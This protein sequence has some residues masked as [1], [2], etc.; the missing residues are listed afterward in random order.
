MDLGYPDGTTSIPGH[1]EP[2]PNVDI[3]QQIAD[4][5]KS[6]GVIVRPSERDDNGN[7][8]WP[9]TRAQVPNNPQHILQFPKDL[10]DEIR[11]GMEIPDDVISA[12]GSGAW[13][14]KRVTLA[15]FYASL[16]HWVVQIIRDLKSQIFDH[17]CLLNWGYVPEYEIA[18]KPLAE[19]AMEQQANAGPGAGGSPYPTRDGDGDGMIG[20][21]YYRS[22]QGPARMSLD[23]VAAVGEGVL[24]A[25]ELVEA[26][27]RVMRMG[28]S[29]YKGDRGGQ[30]W[31]HSETGEVRYQRNKPQD[32]GNA[33]RPYKGNEG[34][35]GLVSPNV[36]TGMS[37]EESINR[38]SQPR[39]Q[40]MK[41]AFYEVGSDLGIRQTQ[42][43]VAGA[44]RDGSE[45]S[46]LTEY[47][48]LR[49]YDELKYV[50]SWQGL[51]ANQ[52]AAIPFLESI[53]GSSRL[54]ETSTQMRVSELSKLLNSLD[55][56]NR[57]LAI[58][59]DGRVRLW[60]VEFDGELET[61]LDRLEKNL[62]QLKYT[63]GQSEMLGDTVT[64]ER[65]PARAIYRDFIRHYE[66]T[67]RDRPHCTSRRQALDGAFRL[68][69]REVPNSDTGRSVVLAIGRLS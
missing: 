65:G 4:K 58:E 5:M 39:H 64:W 10:D 60:L 19:Q 51:L 40:A 7:E 44:W 6:G 69:A 17:L 12:D 35:I 18:H 9:L 54:I 61:G 63:L 43:D 8:M 59:D 47:E 57:T 23:P 42:I 49:D 24:S 28:W 27:Q 67:F 30:G 16:D 41:K 11:R 25:G 66:A 20:E 52:K 26:A 29:P 37:I 56:E 45:N 31:V 53:D 38:F 1:A 68:S 3:A 33:I 62:G 22:M 34:S 13:A 21:G 15:S 55:L 14:G 46:I 50:L 36:D 48:G 2:V 32:D